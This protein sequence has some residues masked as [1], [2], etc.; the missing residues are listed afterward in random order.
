MSG[1]LQ[2][3]DDAGNVTEDGQEDVDELRKLS[4]FPF[5]SRDGRGKVVTYEV[6][7]AATL[8]EHT[9]RGHEDGED[10]LDDIAV[11]DKSAQPRHTKGHLIVTPLRC[12]YDGT[13][14]DVMVS[15]DL[16]VKGMFAVFVGEFEVEVW[17]K[18]MCL[19]V[20]EKS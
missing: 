2:G 13:D 8:E 1:G 16:P 3:V 12:C 20:E 11:R 5:L 17:K 10:D 15:T 19:E 9:D 18:L 4:V 7:T 6:S 14:H